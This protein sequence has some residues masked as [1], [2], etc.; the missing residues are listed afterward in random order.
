MRKGEL[1]QTRRKL[2]LGA[3]LLALLLPAPA[4]SALRFHNG[5]GLQVTSVKQLD[6]RLF[7]LTLQTAALP[8][9]A[10][11][12]I[13]LPPG[14][15]AHRHRRYP[16]FYLL[17]GTSGGAS[18]WTL[19]GNAEQVIGNSPMITVM[20]DIAL[21][22]DGGGWCTDWPNGMER[23]ETFHIGQLL[24]WVDTNLRTIPQ[25]AKRAIAGL[26]QGGFCSLS[27]AARHP[28]LFG[29]ALGY[30]GAP[31][32]WYDAD[33]RVGA[34]AVISA[35]E[36]GLDHLPPDTFFGNQITDGVNWAAHDPAT[37][38]QNLRGTRMY[39]YWGN[40]QPGP[41]DHGPS[42]S[43]GGIESLVARDNADFEARLGSLGIPAYFDDYG[44]GTH[45]WPYWTR[46]LQWSIGKIMSDFNHPLPAAPSYTSADDQY[47]LAGWVVDMHRTAREFSAFSGAS[48]SGFTLAGS[49]SGTVITP[50][51]Y[52]AGRR[53]SVVLSGSK[54]PQQTE[55]LTAPPSRRLQL[56]V[57]LGPPNPF[58][59]YTLQA[60]LA[61][62][63]VYKTAVVIGP[64][65]R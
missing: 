28:D 56:Q 59:Q 58:Q 63:A 37:L 51:L 33:A 31:A 41:L 40:G 19:Q 15:L 25:R 23:W 14:Y 42:I 55:T 46:D 43:A 12:R 2:L 57:P 50:P 45:S 34:M 16:V 54:V 13:L 27:Y 7:A 36:V 44:P 35:T 22:D 52:R 29:V 62:T 9:P 60:Q 61:G 21:N 65:P 5:D 49:G 64:L 3:T 1:G 53:Y 26:S 4:A 38:A 6:P 10:S 18:D 39:M 17:H 30:S 48:R 8:S 20:P 47:A 11:V 32:I 24:P